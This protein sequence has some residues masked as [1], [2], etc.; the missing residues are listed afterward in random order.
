[1]SAPISLPLSGPSWASTRMMIRRESTESTVPARRQTTAAPE[2]LTVMCSMPVPT[3][4]ASARSRGTA[5]RCML[6]A[7]ERAVGV[8]VLQEGHER[9]GHR[10][11]LLGAD[12]HVVDLFALG[13]DEVA[14]VA[15][16][17]TLLLDGAVLAELD[18]GLGD[19]VLVLLPGREV[20]AVGLH[21]RRP[22]LAA[23]HRGVLAL[24]LVALHDVAHLVVGVP[25]LG[26]LVVVQDL[27]LLHLPVRALDEAEL[28]DA[29]EAGERRDEP[30]VR[31]LRRLDGADAAV[32]RGMDVA[33]LEPRALAAEAARPQGR[34]PPLVRDLRERVRLVHE[35]A[36]AGWTR[37]TRG[38]TGHDRLGVDEVVGHGRGHLLVDAHLLLD[39]A[40]HA[41][42]ADAELVLQQLAHAAHPAVA[43]MVDVVHLGRVAAQLQQERDHG[44]DVLGPQD[45]V[46][47]GAADSP[48]LVLSFRRPTRE[49]SYFCG[50]RNIPSKRLR[51][52]SR[53]GGSPGRMRR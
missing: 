11:E 38:W 51:E 17:D 2:S 14:L 7:H 52:E 45:L 40:L 48:S 29:R 20:E 46:G 23:A 19:R 3:S 53:V 47:Q 25:R 4:G 27:A 36:R 24:D 8:V 1:M 15:R 32:V 21:L 12:V 50:F 6:R 43:Q 26:H 5:W 22:L 44:V 33:H 49:K 39:G 35:L 41:D 34:E 28:V 31:A 18:V 37:R 13:Q 10:D 42:E 9:R 30:D 16:G